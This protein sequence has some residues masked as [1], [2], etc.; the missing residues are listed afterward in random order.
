M[1]FREGVYSQQTS[2]ALEDTEQ[3]DYLD[4][5]GPEA[6]SDDPASADSDSFDLDAQYDKMLSDAEKELEQDLKALETPD[7]PRRATG[8][9]LWIGF[10]G[11]WYQ[12]GDTENTILSIQLY[13]PPDQPCFRM[14]LRDEDP[15]MHRRRIERLSCIVYADGPGQDQRPELGRAL[16]RIVTKAIELGVM[17]QEPAEIVVVGFGLRFDLAALRDFQQIK[18]DIDA[19]SGR[20]A[21][22]NALAELGLTWRHRLAQAPAPSPDEPRVPG[23]KALMAGDELGRVL[24]KVRF[25][26]AAS[27]VPIGTSLRYVGKLV[28]REKLGIPAPYSIAR[29]DEFLR[30]NRAAYED[31][32]LRDAEIAVLFAMRVRDFARDRLGLGNLSPTAGGL[33]LKWFLKTVPETLQLSAFGLER[34]RHEGWHQASRRKTTHTVAEPTPMRRLQEAF[35]TDCFKGGRNEA[36]WLGPTDPT[37][38]PIWDYDLASAYATSLLDL[39][40]IDF[41]HPGFSNRIEDYLG[42]VAGY[43]LVDFEHPD[44]V[45]FPVFSISVGSKGLIFPR[46]GT[47][48]ATAPEILAAHGVG[49]RMTIRWGVVYRWVTTPQPEGGADVQEELPRDRLFFDFV[50]VVRET[51]KQLKDEEAQLARQEGRE[52]RKL[53]IEEQ[54]V[55]LLGNSLTGKC[56]QGL[57]PK[58]VYDA[59]GARSVRLQPSAVTNPAIA[60]HITGFMYRPSGICSVQAAIA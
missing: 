12:T 32:A 38:G 16:Q 56:S 49:C 41:E 3:D 31:Y 50:K 19:V 14:P 10:D 45:R 44:D 21:T 1:K 29:M 13:V 51:R 40:R 24:M 18:R 59:R 6:D 7:V 23:S 46:R 39:K 42:H 26:D 15:G 8:E 4:G 47:A 55:K 22:V 25:I 37:L 30:K 28:G 34:V 54:F 57:R 20:V 36:Y 17:A 60:A 2:T 27:Y 48:Y 11:E 9:A 52:P 35:L 53:L 43:A 5:D 33:A 58:N